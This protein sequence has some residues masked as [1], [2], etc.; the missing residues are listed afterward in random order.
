M[1]DP[2]YSGHDIVN[3]RIFTAPRELLW[4]AWTEPEH[5][6]QW[7]GP[8]GFR[9]TFREF[10][11]REG[12]HWRFTMHG[13][14]GTDYENEIVFREIVRPERLVLDHVEPVHR[15]IV[16]ATFANENGKTRVTFRMR[17]DSADECARVRSFVVDANEQN[18][19]RLEAELAKM[20]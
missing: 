9:N 5:L 11:L 13:P 1:S 20:R 2:D 6:A 10:D 16:T 15:F 4:R 7:W 8:N 18:F 19:D 3:T 14:D 12:G 17:F